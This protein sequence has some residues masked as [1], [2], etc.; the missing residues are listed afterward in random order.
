[1]VEK[2]KQLFQSHEEFLDYLQQKDPK[3]AMKRYLTGAIT[4]DISRLGASSDTIMFS[5]TSFEEYKD[6]FKNEIFKNMKKRI[7]PDA[8]TNAPIV[9]H[10]K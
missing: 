8:I 10:N 7:P 5:P 2:D 6:K 9:E 1:M 3:N 4:S